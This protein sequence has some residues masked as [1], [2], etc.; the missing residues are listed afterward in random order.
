MAFGFPAV[1]G[2]FVPS[3]DAT[4]KLI[5]AFS[6]NP[7]DFALNKY[8]SITNVDKVA[9]Y[10]MRI[11]PEQA[12]RVINSNL[13]E[14]AWPEGN[15]APN[16]D[17]GTESHSFFNYA[18][19]RYTSGFRLGTLTIDQAVWDIV[20]SHAAMTAQRMMTA[21]TVLTWNALLTDSNY[22]AGQTDTATNWSGGFLN[23][24]TPTAPNLK[25]GL[26]KI[27]RTLVLSTLGVVSLKD[28]VFVSDPVVFSKL[29]ESQEVHTYVKESPVA[30]EELRGEGNLNQAWNLPGQMY[31]LKFVC[32]DAVRVTTVKGATTSGSF[33]VGGNDAVVIARPGG[34]SSQEGAPSFSSIHLFMKEEMTVETKDDPDNRRT[35]GRIVENYDVQMVAPVSSVRIKNVLS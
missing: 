17:W 1:A 33:I 8:V 3:F 24:G 20:A 12:A 23:A 13:Y 21:R 34:L 29:G 31:G 22:P 15:D 25:I 19:K 5:V 30:S 27:V 10:Y 9:G 7:K 11:T 2:V 4:G 35:K 32:E 16:E 14:M 28:L 26:N 18:C 6:R